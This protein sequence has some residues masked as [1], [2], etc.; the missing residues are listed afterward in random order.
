MRADAKHLEPLILLWGFLIDFLDET[1]MPSIA[2]LI[3][4]YGKM[5]TNRFGITTDFQND[6]GIGIYLGPSIIDHSCKPNAIAVF[7]G[8]TIVVRTITDLPS[9][10]W[11]QVLAKMQI[12]VK[13][14]LTLL[15]YGFNKFNVIDSIC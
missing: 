14:Y 10:D 9:L 7:E 5:C 2:E 11:S 8:T 6:I 15:F 3:S 4:I 13:K 1:L 12:L